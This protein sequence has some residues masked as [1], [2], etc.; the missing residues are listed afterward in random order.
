MRYIGAIL[1]MFFSAFSQGF[2]QDNTSSQEGQ[3]SGVDAGKPVEINADALEVQQENNMA[4]FTGNVIAVQG[5]TRLKAN[6]MVVHYRESKQRTSKEQ[7]AVEKIDVFGDVVLS[8]PEEAATGDKG[9]YQVDEKKVYLY[10]NVV[11]SQKS[12]VLKGD[13][14][15]HNLL[16]RQSVINGPVLAT[17]PDGRKSTRVKALFIPDNEKADNEKSEN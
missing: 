9:V 1:V 8:T 12:N 15:V 2:A 3:L 16:T 7:G 11:L 4:I 5:Q 14:L 13:A 17:H 6:K 10:D